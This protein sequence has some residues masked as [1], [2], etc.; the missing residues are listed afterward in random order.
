[1]AEHIDMIPSLGPGADFSPDRRYRYRL[2]R[3]WDCSKPPLVWLLL[4]PSTA[5]EREDDPTMRRCM[6]FAHRDGHGGIV[7]LNIFAFRSTDPRVLK[8]H[9]DSGRD[10]IGPENDEYIQAYLCMTNGTLKSQTKFILGYGSNGT[11]AGRDKQIMQMVAGYDN[12]YCLG[13]TATGQ[14]RHPLYIRGEQR[15][16]KFIEK[17][18]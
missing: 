11:M 7:V 2:W 9:I 6:G 1:M 4:N 14:P 17:R 10:M 12:I 13:Y 18:R 3:I 8:Y 15:F 5:D 16:V